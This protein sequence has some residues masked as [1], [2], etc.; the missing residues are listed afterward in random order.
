MRDWLFFLLLWLGMGIAAMVGYAMH[1]KV[2]PRLRHVPLGPL[3]SVY[4]MMAWPLPKW[5]KP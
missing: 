3:V 4:M 1:F 5:A 2:V